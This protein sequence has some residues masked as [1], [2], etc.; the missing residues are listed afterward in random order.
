M[1]C[2]EQLGL[3]PST[4]WRF[5]HLLG[6]AAIIACASLSPI[7]EATEADGNTSN[8]SDSAEL[9]TVLS[10]VQI[11]DNN[12]DAIMLTNDGEWIVTHWWDIDASAGAPFDILEAIQDLLGDEDVLVFPNWIRAM[13]MNQAGGWAVVSANGDFAVGGALPYGFATRLNSAISL[14]WNI[15]DIELTDE[16]FAIVAA[17]G[18]YTTRRFESN[19]DGMDLVLADLAR[20]NRRLQQIEVGFDNRWTVVAD[21]NPFTHEALFDQRYVLEEMARSGWSVDVLEL[22]IGDDF[23]AVSNAQNASSADPIANAIEYGLGSS[24]T[25]T[26]WT[27]MAEENIPGVAIGVIEDGDVAWARGYG[28]L[29]A[30]TEKYQDPVLA[31]TTFDIASLSKY[32]AALAMLKLHYDD[33]YNFDLDDPVIPNYVM[34]PSLTHWYTAGNGLLDGVDPTE[35]YGIEAD[36]PLYEEFT[37]RDL[38]RHQAKFRT[39]ASTAIPEVG[40]SQMP[41]VPTS[42]WLLGWSCTEDECG[43]NLNDQHVWTDQ[44]IVGF[45]YASPGYMVVQAV[46][47]TVYD[48]CTGNIGV[49]CPPDY[50]DAWALVNREIVFPMDLRFTTAR[51]FNGAVMVEAGPHDANGD[52]TE[53]L[54]YPWT[55]AGGITSTADDYAE[56]VV[57]VLNDGTA[58]NGVEILPEEAIDE[59]FEASVAYPLYGL[60]IRFDDDP[61]RDDFFHLGSHPNHTRSYFCGNRRELDGIVILTNADYDPSDANGSFFQDILAAFTT[62]MAWDPAEDCQQ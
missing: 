62:E 15:V 6:L 24:G 20:S 9:W 10:D 25:T 47:E 55:Y 35:T 49:V 4:L 50:D 23:V 37:T 42:A 41:D 26:I 52:P 31:N 40:W 46:A 32:V 45:N 48:E 16:G 34:S 29:E 14:G 2:N 28:V 8:L 51:E 36:Q 18:R 44:S 13:D 43:Y 5:F 1:K 57:L 17:D 59:L 60:G 12:I 39:Q 33:K 58:S 56:L 7:G 54:E 11:N 19:F 3:A 30:S 61:A 27:R 22:G 21:Q 53:W 38:L